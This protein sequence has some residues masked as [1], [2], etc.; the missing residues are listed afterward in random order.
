MAL[1]PV[2]GGG[3]K[4]KS[5]PTPSPVPSF[6]DRYGPPIGLD[7]SGPTI[8]PDRSGPTIQ[9]AYTGPI[10]APRSY[11]CSREDID[12]LCKFFDVAGSV[13][14]GFMRCEMSTTPAIRAL[15]E[16]IY[17]GASKTFTTVSIV[18]DAGMGLY[19]NNSNGEPATKVI[20]DFAG[21]TIS[22]G[23]AALTTGAVGECAA[24]GLAAVGTGICPGIGTAAGYVLGWG[25]GCLT[26][27]GVDKLVDLGWDWVW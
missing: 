13:G 27:W 26:G 2:L 12:L 4:K 14:T 5:T 15:E 24:S 23:A 16:S 1:D 18:L 22:A 6:N 19:E 7:R 11:T 17:K 25:V 3:T 20:C 10:G 9:P 8:Q 21:D